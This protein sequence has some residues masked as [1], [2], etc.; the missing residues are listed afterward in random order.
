MRC[1]LCGQEITEDE[2]FS[3][4][5]E[6]ETILIC[7]DCYQEGYTCYHCGEYFKHSYDLFEINGEYYCEECAD[8]LFYRCDDCGEYIEHIWSSAVVNGDRVCEYCLEN[9][10]TYCEL[11]GEYVLNDDAVYNEYRDCYICPTCAENDLSILG[12]YHHTLAH[13][14]F[15]NGEMFLG[16]ELEIDHGNDLENCV[17]GLRQN[18][19]NNFYEYKYDG[20]LDRGIEVVSQPATLNYHM[21]IAEWRKVI[22]I[23]LQNGFKSHD[24][25]TCGLH[26]HVNRNYFNNDDKAIL[27]L[28]IIFENNRHWL[29][30][31]SRRNIDS[32]NHWASFKPEYEMD[33]LIENGFERYNERYQAINNTNSQTIEFRLFRGTLKYNT[34]VA[35][36]QFVYWLCEY[37]NS[38]TVCECDTVELSQV[39]FSEFSELNLYLQE[40]G[41][42]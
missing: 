36:L 21:N 40:R 9:N 12:D 39:D 8:R 1:K 6:G 5:Y 15:G 11:C 41:L 14:F 17:V 23:A 20:S 29:E 22:D 34:F 42:K 3:V 35:T 13:E 24:C 7:D 26:V 19:S 37:V 16:V 32:L 33:Y 10:Y 38:H 28:W 4:N 18:T 25:G 27:K 30:V 2:S 31:F